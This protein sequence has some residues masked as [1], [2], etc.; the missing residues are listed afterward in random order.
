VGGLPTLAA[1]IGIRF[2][3]ELRRPVAA[4]NLSCHCEEV[5][6]PSRIRDGFQ[7][8]VLWT[9]PVANNEQFDLCAGQSA[10]C[11]K[12]SEDPYLI[13]ASVDL[14]KSEGQPITL[15]HIHTFP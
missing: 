15:E 2:A 3:E 7:L 6:R 9:A 8:D 11:P 12:C 5:I 14:P 4:Q 13:L 1:Y 10:P